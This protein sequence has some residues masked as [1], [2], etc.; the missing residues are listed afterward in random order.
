[1]D[2]DSYFILWCNFVLQM[3]KS[4]IHLSSLMLQKYLNNPVEVYHNKLYSMLPRTHILQP[5]ANRKK[6]THV[7]ELEQ[8]SY[9][10]Q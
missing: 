9:T 4:N 8:H 7:E 6:L 3:K 1:M 10:V 5:P 2:F